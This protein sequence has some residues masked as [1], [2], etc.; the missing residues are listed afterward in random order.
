MDWKERREKRIRMTRS[1]F[2]P[3]S[4]PF[5]SY[6]FLAI[7]HNLRTFFPFFMLFFFI[8]FLSYIFLGVFL[9]YIFLFLVHLKLYLIMSQSILILYVQSYAICKVGSIKIDL[10]CSKF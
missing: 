7:T 3:P 1:I 10:F 4:L 6:V 9:S 8:T 2:L 5:F